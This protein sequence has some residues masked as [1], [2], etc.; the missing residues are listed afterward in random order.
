MAGKKRVWVFRHGP[1]AS[2]PAKDGIFASASLKEPEGR[3]VI[4]KIVS[5]FLK[6]QKFEG[7]YTSNLVRAYQTGVI[8]AEI[9]GMEF[10]HL[11]EG[12]G[13][14]PHILKLWAGL[15]AGLKSYTCFDFFIADPVFVKSEG[16]RVFNTI[17]WLATNATPEGE[18]ILC[19]SHGG[20]I[21]PAVATAHSLVS[22]SFEYE[23][24]RIADLKECE[25]IIFVFDDENKFL[26]VHELRFR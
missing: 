10:P 2:G 26:E 16:E 22:Q 17:I 14:P 21:E 24:Y 23:I 13:A 3:E 7:I 5:T 1:K 6:G 19:V 12:L 9:L 11:V 4:E 8:L 25:G 15:I 20:L 18:Q